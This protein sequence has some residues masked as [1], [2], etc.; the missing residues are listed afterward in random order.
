LWTQPA[1]PRFLSVDSYVTSTQSDVIS[2]H[3]APGDVLR[4]PASDV[5]THVMHGPEAEMND[6]SMTSAYRISS[7]SSRSDDVFVA[8]EIDV[9]NCVDALLPAPLDESPTTVGEMLFLSL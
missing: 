4:S 3:S 5:N 1:K 7:D 9:S 6:A 2:L 8:E